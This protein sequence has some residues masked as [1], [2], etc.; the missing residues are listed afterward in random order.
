MEIHAFDID[1]ALTSNR[2]VESFKQEQN[3][4]NTV[5]IVSARSEIGI[6]EFLDTQPLHPTF[7]KSARIKSL[8][9]R[10]IRSQYDGTAYVYHGSWMR[11]RVAARLAGWKY[12]EF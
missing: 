11:D 4:G 5:G 9:L 1:G 10:N 2:G 7:T 3:R 12:Q 6:R 8:A